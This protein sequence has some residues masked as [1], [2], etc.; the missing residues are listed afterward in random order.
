MPE[1]DTGAPPKTLIIVATVV[2]VAF[3]AAVA[4]V[5]VTMTGGSGDGDDSGPLALPAVPAPAAQSEKCSTLLQTLPNKL[6]SGD[7]S[8]HTRELA[9]PAP[10]GAHAWGGT[11]TGDPVV[12]RCGVQRPAELTTTSRLRVI[13]DV[14]WLGVPGE[15][16][17]TWY[18]VDRPVYVALTLPRGAGTGPIQTVSDAIAKTLEPTQL[19]FPG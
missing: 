2:A 11:P 6:E 7:D 13:N 16:A 17:T 8:L 18:A 15:T 12:L 14:Q 19:R 9:E 4:V 3:A 5:G 10:Q 1:T